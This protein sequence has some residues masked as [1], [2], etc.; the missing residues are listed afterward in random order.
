MTTSLPL[1]AA[2][3][4]FRLLMSAQ[5]VSGLADNAL[6]LVAIGRLA[7]E[8]G[9]VWLPPLLK[10]AFTLAYVLLL[11]TGVILWW[12]KRWPGNW[13]IEL[14]KSLVRALFDMHR[15]GGVIMGLLI[16]VSILIL[17]WGTAGVFG[18]VENSLGFKIIFGFPGIVLA[19]IFVTVPFVIRETRRKFQHTL[20]EV[21]IWER[22]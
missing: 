19:S 10:L 15:I 13:R 21:T 17:L 1:P 6:L 22:L 2:L 14:N 16:A 5:F 8:G 11:L 20:S 12:P 18:F 9:P 3:R 7:A 4:G